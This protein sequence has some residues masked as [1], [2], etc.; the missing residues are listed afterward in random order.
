MFVV[1]TA[2]TCMCRE[3]ALA[4]FPGV[5]GIHEN[6]VIHVGHVGVSVTM[7]VFSVAHCPLVYTC[8]CVGG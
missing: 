6:E 3:N 2:C 7:V 1:E 5:P 4:S 8:T